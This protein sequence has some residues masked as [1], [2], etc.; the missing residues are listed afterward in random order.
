MGRSKKKCVYFEMRCWFASKEIIKLDEIVPVRI[1]ISSVLCMQ[2][3]TNCLFSLEI[4]RDN[5]NKGCKGVC[6]LLANCQLSY[7]VKF[8]TNIS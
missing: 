1:M 3:V 4:L 5:P 8:S 2:A 7:M 6:D